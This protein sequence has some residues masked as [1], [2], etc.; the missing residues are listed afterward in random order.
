[1]KT[2]RL[3][4]KPVEFNLSEYISKGYELFKANMGT[5]ILS[6]LAVMVFSI[7]PI[8]AYLAIGNFLKICRKLNR[9]EQASAGDVFDFTDFKKFFKLLL[10]V[11]LGVLVLEIPYF[12]LVGGM[13]EN[14]STILPM[15]AM[16]YLIFITVPIIYFT[17]KMYYMI[18]LMALEGVDSI[19]EAWNMSKVMTK[20]NMLVIIG[21]SIVVGIIGQ[22]GFIACLVGILFTLPL[23]YVIQYVAYEHG[24]DQIQ[25]K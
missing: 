4:P 24:L 19:K 25:T 23:A 18:P 10:I 15:F 22:L 3:T 13:R 20:G 12:A 16:L 9:G 17:I 11:F 2:Y 1:M 5:F 14:D 7:I 6:F 21:F 8:F